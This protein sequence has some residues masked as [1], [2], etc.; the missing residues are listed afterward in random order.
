MPLAALNPKL[1]HHALVFM[2]RDRANKLVDSGRSG[3][4]QP[5]RLS[6]GNGLRVYSKLWNL[7]V[8]FGRALVLEQERR[9]LS[10]LQGE[11]L[12]LECEVGHNDGQLRWRRLA[13][14]ED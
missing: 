14:H 11:L 4:F 5:R 13:A 12:R 10:G 1:S 8:V 7:E 9:S 3:H 2:A 6:G